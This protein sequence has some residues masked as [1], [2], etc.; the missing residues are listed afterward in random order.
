[1]LQSAPRRPLPSLPTRRSSD[2][3]ALYGLY[4]SDRHAILSP[5]EESPPLQASLARPGTRADWVATPS[6]P[7]RAYARRAAGGWEV[8]YLPLDRKSTRLNSSHDQN[9]YAVFC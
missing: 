1:L 4:A 7:A 5:W 2:L 3:P 6:G 9:S 8:V